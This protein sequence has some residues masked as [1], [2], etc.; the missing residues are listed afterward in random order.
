MEEDAPWLRRRCCLTVNPALALGAASCELRA[1]VCRAL[2][3]DLFPCPTSSY[4]SSRDNKWSHLIFTYL[5]HTTNALSV[6]FL[7]PI[8]PDGESIVALCT[9]GSN[10]KPQSVLGGQLRSCGMAISGL[11]DTLKTILVLFHWRGKATWKHSWRELVALQITPF[12]F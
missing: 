10:F 8:G 12:A 7:F 1:P 5:R 9:T 2:Q 4:V 6:P 11:L 3:D